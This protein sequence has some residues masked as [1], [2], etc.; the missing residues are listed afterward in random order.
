MHS[1]H[2]RPG[3]RI[4]KDAFG[5]E[6]V[7]EHNDIL[8]VLNL[9]S[10]KHSNDSSNNRDP[11]SPHR[12]RGKVLTVGDIIRSNRGSG[13]AAAN[14]YLTADA[15]AAHLL[16]QQYTRKLLSHLD[17][18][19]DGEDVSFIDALKMAN[20]V[21][22]DKIK[23][24]CL[25]D[26]VH[27]GYFNIAMVTTVALSTIQVG[28]ATEADTPEMKLFSKVLDN[29]CCTIFVMEAVLKFGA[30]GVFEYFAVRWNRFDF[31][32]CSI[33]VLETWIIPQSEGI[34]VYLRGTI[35]LRSLRMVRVVRVLRL[36][37]YFKELWL[38]LKG[39]ANAMKMVGWVVLLL[40]VV[41]AISSI[42]CR[43][44]IAKKDTMDLSDQFSQD[45]LFGSMVRSM[46]TLF[47]I[48]LLT[49]D[50]DAISRPL[51]EENALFFG[52]LVCFLFMSTFSLLNVIVGVVVDDVLMNQKSNSDTSDYQQA[53][54]HSKMMWDIY[55]DFFELDSNHDG[56]VDLDEFLASPR[57]T[58]AIHLV[59]ANSHAKNDG[60]DSCPAAVKCSGKE[61]FDC[62]DI[63]RDGALTRKEF[64]LGMIRT[65]EAFRHPKQ[66]FV[67]LI[68][69]ARILLS[70]LRALE[71]ES[72][73]SPHGVPPSQAATTA[74]GPSFDGRSSATLPATTLQQSAP[75]RF[76]PEPPH[77][78]DD[79]D[80]LAWLRTQLERNDAML[81][82]VARSLGA[83]L[84]AKP[85]PS[86]P[87][88]SAAVPMSARAMSARGRS[89]EG[90]ADLMR[91]LMGTGA[92]LW[93]S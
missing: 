16:I 42:L 25:A 63:N 81:E 9:G 18:G 72:P 83:T 17:E 7:R 22:D 90:A 19:E 53:L 50:W 58:D 10:N 47:N 82:S 93:G 31:T 28:V 71:G 38:V 77:L 39:L 67:S 13:S 79:S 32:L 23:Q 57:V 48:V 61:L 34:A 43:E 15:D 37:K 87:P 49:E 6:P 35:A 86:R 26:I 8:N 45:Q 59:A 5:D 74:G 70:D 88:Q 2:V 41:L 11:E 92:P 36:F 84:S 46:I 78:N 85:A 3:K 54:V 80:R 51:F 1:H 12:G 14:V 60:K 91:T 21:R 52:L 33:N 66:T 20:R 75:Q 27:S 64:T 29:V 56:L 40:L 76:A 44:T 55:Q 4:S 30:Y 69:Q 62:M 65:L 73:H 68:G 89:H 24:P